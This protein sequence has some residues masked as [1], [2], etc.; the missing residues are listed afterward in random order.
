MA[1]G[2]AFRNVTPKTFKKFAE[3]VGVG[4]KISEQ[5]VVFNLKWVKG[6]LWCALKHTLLVITSSYSWIAFRRGGR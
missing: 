3:L 1:I 2:N 6:G 4:K 5:Q